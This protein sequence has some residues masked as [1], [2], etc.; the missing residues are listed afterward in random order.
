MKTPE[1]LDS[2]YGPVHFQNAV[3]F[4]QELGSIPEADGIVVKVKALEP[5]IDGEPF[6]RLSPQYFKAVELIHTHQTFNVRHPRDGRNYQMRSPLGETAI[7]LVTTLSNLQTFLGDE[8]DALADELIQEI[9]A[10]APKYPATE[11]DKLAAAAL[12]EKRANRKK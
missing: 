2:K 5:Y 3:K 10:L 4:A 7:R 12:F 9:G 11:A 8:G 6:A 1:Y